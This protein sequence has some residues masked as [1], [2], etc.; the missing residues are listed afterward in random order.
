ME[1]GDILEGDQLSRN[2]GILDL[3]VPVGKLSRCSS[4]SCA[5]GTLFL[6]SSRRSC[7]RL[8]MIASVEMTRFTTWGPG[9]SSIY[10]FWNQSPTC[11]VPFL[12][13]ELDPK[14]G[15][16]W[17]PTFRKRRNAGHESI[18]QGSHAVAWRTAR[19]TACGSFTSTKYSSGYK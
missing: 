3:D 14:S 2:A 8:V 9:K 18:T 12:A 17:D 13:Q 10:C 4:F 15:G 5:V 1:L 16:P 11:L 6:A 19:S 7:R